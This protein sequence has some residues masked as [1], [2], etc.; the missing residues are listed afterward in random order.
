MYIVEKYTGE[1]TYM[2]PNGAI[3]DRESVLRDFPA[4]LTFVHIV[5]TD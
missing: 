5:T 3:Y 1:K 4:A 2:A